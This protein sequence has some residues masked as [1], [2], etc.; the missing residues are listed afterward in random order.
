MCEDLHK[1]MSGHAAPAD[2]SY[3]ALLL[4][5]FLLNA[6][7]WSSVDHWG[8]TLG[9][10]YQARGWFSVL[11]LFKRRDKL[12]GYMADTSFYEKE[13]LVL[14]RRAVILQCAPRRAPRTGWSYWWHPCTTV[15]PQPAWQYWA[16]CCIEQVCSHLHLLL[17]PYHFGAGCQPCTLPLIQIIYISLLQLCYYPHRQKGIFL[18]GC[19]VVPFDS[20]YMQSERKDLQRKASKGKNKWKERKYSFSSALVMLAWENSKP[21]SH[22]LTPLFFFPSTA[23]LLVQPSRSFPVCHFDKEL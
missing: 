12:S 20:Y 6:E 19:L 8:P 9:C 3:Q 7:S 1:C 10:Y 17:L 4:W 16:G 18:A 13:N 14:R 11:N 15:T 2:Y 5:G 21:T 23:V 22:W